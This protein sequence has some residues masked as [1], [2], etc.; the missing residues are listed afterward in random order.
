MRSQIVAAALLAGAGLAHG[1]V[2]GTT[3]VEAAPAAASG[4]SAAGGANVVLSKEATSVSGDGKTLGADADGI[5]ALNEARGLITAGHPKEAIDGHLDPLLARLDVEYR[6]L[7]GKRWCANT[8][9]ELLFYLMQS[10]M[11]HQQATAVDGNLCNAYFL[12]G[13]AE[14]DLGQ[15]AAAEADFERA[16]AL[17]PNNPHYLSEMGDL[18]LRRHDDA[19]ALDYFKRAEDGAKSFAPKDRETHEL[20][21]ALRGTG[22]AQVELGKLADA[23]A[24]YRRCLEVDPADAKAKAELGYVLEQRAKLA[25]SK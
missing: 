18:H 9:P 12:R 1:I 20:A 5:K 24:S 4:A 15:V 17:S 21:R 14:V 23:E 25:A 16:L 19:G 2:V 7:A 3:R 11:A 8:T 22:Y 13:Y 6:N 10:A